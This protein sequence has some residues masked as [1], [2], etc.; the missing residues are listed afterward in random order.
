MEVKVYEVG[1]YSPLGTR[2]VVPDPSPKEGSKNQ[3]DRRCRPGMSAIREYGL[4]ALQPQLQSGDDQPLDLAGAL[5]DL[6]DARIP[7]VAL[8]GQFL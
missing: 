8:D 1:P 5:V 3:R 2:L 4:P 7:K 6:G